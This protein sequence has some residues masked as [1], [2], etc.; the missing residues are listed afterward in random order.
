MVRALPGARDG[1]VALA[2]LAGGL[3]L[4]LFVP[5][6]RVVWWAPPVAAATRW[7][8]LALVVACLGCTQRRTHPLLGLGAGAAALLAGP[9]VIGISG[10]GVVLA[11]CDTLY[12]AV[13]RG[14]RRA[15]RTVAR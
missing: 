11:F 15:S 13:L 8:L 9:A 7:D 1:A 14:G 10:T 3:L 2:L 5:G 4:A 6:S 12:N